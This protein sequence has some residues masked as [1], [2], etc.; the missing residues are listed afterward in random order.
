[1]RGKDLVRQCTHKAWLAAIAA[2][3]VP[4]SAAEYSVS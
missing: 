4:L 2:A 3:A 1:M